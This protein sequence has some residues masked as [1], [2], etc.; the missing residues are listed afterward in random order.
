MKTKQK[1]LL[2]EG[3]SLSS[4]ETLTALRH[5]GYQIDILSCARFPLSAFSR[6]RHKVIRTVNA[7]DHPRAYLEHM[8]KLVKAEKY[9]AVLPTHEQARLIAEAKILLP[10]SIPAAVAPAGAFAQTQSKMEF[11]RLLDVLGIPQPAW[12]PVV[13]GQSIRLPFPFWVKSEYGT[14]GQSVYK[15]SNTRQLTAAMAS[16]PFTAG[17]L[18]LAQANAEGQYGQVQALFDEGKMV[19]VHTSVQTGTGVG[20]SAAAR[21]S[22]NFPAT[23]RHI[24]M[25]GEYLCWQGPITI[26]FIHRGGQPLYIECNPRMVEPANAERAGVNFPH[27]L[28]QLTTGAHF[29]GPPQVGAPGVN[30]HSLQALLLGCAAQTGT[31]RAVLQTMLHFAFGKNSAEVLT[32]LWQDFPSI[33]PLAVVFTALLISPRN[34]GKFAHSAIKAYAVLPKTIEKL[35]N[36]AAR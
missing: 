27:L 22:V 7:N 23:R 3:S 26:D 21:Q 29:G 12:Q 13:A 14:A 31:R 19:A 10:G 34:A 30:T 24:Q 36:Q 32:P 25:V 2:T 33:I 4:R 15:V 18:L 16:L 28:V 17:T 20:N 9:C 6:W 5:C 8:A 1:I 35:R 11:A